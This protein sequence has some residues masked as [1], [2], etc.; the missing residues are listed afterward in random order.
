M[1]VG[2][3]NLIVLL[4]GTFIFLSSGDPSGKGVLNYLVT[5][6]EEVAAKSSSL[7]TYFFKWGLMSFF[8]L[9]ASLHII[10]VTKSLY[11]KS[12]SNSN[13]IL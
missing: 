3:W 11:D 9:E 12:K 6:P 1:I 8:I 7:M 2:G 10:R 4:V 5:G 13:N